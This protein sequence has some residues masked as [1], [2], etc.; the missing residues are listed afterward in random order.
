MIADFFL[1]ARKLDT[2]LAMVRERMRQWLELQPPDQ[3][4]LIE[5]DQELASIA[6]VEIK[7]RVTFP[8]QTCAP[9]RCTDSALEASVPLVF[10]IK[11]KVVSDLIPENRDFVT[12]RLRSAA[13]SLAPYLPVTPNCPSWH[14]LAVGAFS[15]D[16]PHYA[17]RCRLPPRLPTSAQPFKGQLAA[18]PGPD[19]CRHLRFA[20]RPEPRRQAPRYRFS[21]AGRIFPA[22]AAGIRTVHPRAACPLV[23]TLDKVPQ[24]DHCL[25]PPEIN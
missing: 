2:P 25:Y 7:Q 3:F 6:V 14:C 1:A 10:S 21:A 22:G 17:D 15:E 4:L 18:W 13:D 23:V 5:P 19:L 8:V 24:I 16:S 12:L 11:S 9:E 20:D